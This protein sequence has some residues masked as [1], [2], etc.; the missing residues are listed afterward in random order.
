MDYCYNSSIRDIYYWRSRKGLVSVEGSRFKAFLSSNSL[1]LCFVINC[2]VVPKEMAQP[3]PGTDTA[4]TYI[5]DFL[6]CTSSRA[7]WLGPRVTDVAAPAL[8]AALYLCRTTFSPLPSWTPPPTPSI[9]PARH[10]CPEWHGF[11][12]ARRGREDHRFKSAHVAA[13]EESLFQRGRKAH[14]YQG[15]QLGEIYRPQQAWSGHS[16]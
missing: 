15:G 3:N 5:D 10:I 7:S 16:W 13:R 4:Q 2:P 12:T 1:W 8:S 6:S 9:H 11:R 14:S